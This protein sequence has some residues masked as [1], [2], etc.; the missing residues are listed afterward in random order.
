MPRLRS[1]IP[2]YRHAGCA[3]VPES[4]HALPH[5]RWAAPCTISLSS[6]P[7]VAHSSACAGSAALPMAA[8]SLFSSPVWVWTSSILPLRHRGRAGCRAG[9]LPLRM[10]NEDY[11]SIQRNRKLSP[12]FSIRLWGR[13]RY[14]IKKEKPRFVIRR[15]QNKPQHH[16]RIIPVSFIKRSARSA[17]DASLFR[18]S[19]KSGRARLVVYSPD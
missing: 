9:W 2:Q 8:S 10:D 3:G 4:H 17:K 6:L 14:S 5:L 11:E 15:Q 1:Y 19:G 16:R 7:F 12:S 18:R 13:S